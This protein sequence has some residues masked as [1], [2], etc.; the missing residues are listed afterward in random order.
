MD[1][2]SKFQEEVASRIGA[3]HAD[4]AWQDLSL[5]WMK[6]AL[7]KL[8]PYNFSFLGRP[9]I[10]LPQ[11]IV[12]VQE[13]IWAVKP[14]LIIETGVAHGGSLIMSAGMLAL[15]DYCEAAE[16][17]AKLDPAK[18]RRRVVGIDI[19]IR[20]HNR[21]A[22]EAHPL[23][24]LIQLLEGSSVAPDV[25]AKVSAIARDHIKTL[26]FL[27]SSHT[28]DHASAEL[29]HY[30][31]LVS[32][33]SYCVMFDTI[34]EDMPQGYYSDRPWDKGNSPKLAVRAYLDRLTSEVITAA[35]GN[36]LRFEIDER[37]PDKLMLTVSPDGFLKRL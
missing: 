33:G 35:D 10:Q 16:Q 23:A 7:H 9:I 24:G 5:Q 25:I 18:S 30:A 34:I 36:R 19:D 2:I 26:V 3:Y 21:S 8:Y 32:Q 4:N 17:G 6:V 11:D 31:P 20:S 28:F 29:E 37:I 13:L 12:A 15:L 22:I 27:D 14:D 1:E